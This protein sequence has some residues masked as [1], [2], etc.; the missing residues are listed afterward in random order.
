MD[1]I[2]ITAHSDK[3]QDFNEHC[4]EYFIGSK[5]K[6]LPNSHVWCSIGNAYCIFLQCTEKSNSINIKIIK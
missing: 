1:K 4:I 6:I 2:I 5:A 3:K